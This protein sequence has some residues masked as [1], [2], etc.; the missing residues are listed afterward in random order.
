MGGLDRDL[1]IDHL[2]R[3]P[4]CVNPGHLEQVTQRINNL[5]GTG[6]TAMHAQ[7][8]HCKNSH[9]FDE[10]NTYIKPN[11]TRRCRACMAAHSRHYRKTDKWQAWSSKYPKPALQKYCSKG[12][13][14]TNENIILIGNGR[15]R[16]RI[17]Y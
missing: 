13:L 11:G 5:R 7:Q 12:H 1:T 10:A 17:C 15:R 6:P 8:T 3:N 16:C 14:Y 9:V 4:A 2:C